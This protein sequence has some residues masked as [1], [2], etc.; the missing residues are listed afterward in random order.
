MKLACEIA[1]ETIEGKKCRVVKEF[2]ETIFAGAVDGRRIGVQNV[3]R[4][5]LDETDRNETLVHSQQMMQD[6]DPDEYQSHSF[7]ETSVS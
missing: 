7:L 2:A 5:I 4:V 6:E 3:K 1:L